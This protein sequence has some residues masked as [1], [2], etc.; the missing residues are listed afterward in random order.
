M[1]IIK[2]FAIT[3]ILFFIIIGCGKQ[4]KVE[5]KASVANVSALLS[6]Q[7]RD[8]LVPNFSWN[9]ADG[10]AINFDSFREEVTLINFW[11]TWCAPCKKE[12]PDLIAI[13]EEFASK[14]VRIIGIS[15]D[16]GT[17]V[18]TEVSDFLNEN[19]VTYPNVLDNG[20]LASAF[21]NIRGLPTTFLI[22][23]EGKI[24]DRFLGIRTK[25]FFIEKINQLLQ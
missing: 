1:V 13:N 10:K 12:L 4:E 21:G 8:G 6:V 24:V 7:T 20:E 19:K 25:E 5:S 9:G 16:R 22:N 18:I 23:K 15:T 3:L 11:A 17:N 2:N 14:G